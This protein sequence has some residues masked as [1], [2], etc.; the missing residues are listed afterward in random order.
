MRDQA[1]GVV[2]MFISGAPVPL[3]EPEDRYTKTANARGRRG[4]E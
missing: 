1:A 3:A 2:W 4:K